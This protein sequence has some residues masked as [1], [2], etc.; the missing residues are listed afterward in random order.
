MNFKLQPKNGSLVKAKASLK[1]LLGSL[2]FLFALW[3]LLLYK[4]SYPPFTWVCLSFGAMLIAAFRGA[5]SWR[6]LFTLSAIGLFLYRFVGTG[7]HLERIYPVAMAISASILF[8]QGEEFLVKTISKFRDLHS[9]Q[10]NRLAKISVLWTYVLLGNTAILA[11]FLFF[12]SHLLWLLY[13][14][15]VSYVLIGIMVTLTVVCVH[16]D[17]IKNLSNAV[18]S[19]VN[20]VFNFSIFSVLCVFGIPFVAFLYVL[21]LGRK[22]LYA[23]VTQRICFYVFRFVVLQTRFF[24]FID[25][26]FVDRTDGGATPLL[27]CNHLC[28]FDI[29]SIFS[30]FPHCSTFVNAKFLNNPLL[31]PFV[32][33]CDFVVVSNNDPIANQKAFHAAKVKLLNGV[34]FAVFPEG[35]RSKDGRLGILKDGAFRLA[36]ETGVSITPVFFT[37]NRPFLNGGPIFQLRRGCIKFTGFIMPPIDVSTFCGTKDGVNLLKTEFLKRYEEFIS[38]QAILT[39]GASQ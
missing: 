32:R 24:N 6:I 34:T 18:I 7:F 25:I 8:L 29:V 5:L 13:T 22:S 3:M 19:V 39:E 33:A 26:R 35:T 15:I 20:H 27:I 21:C 1:L 28:M 31:Y 36:L 9:E 17:R 23:P 11:G 4:A 30:K 2:Q 10:K 14:G 37:L 16:W 38:S 12:G